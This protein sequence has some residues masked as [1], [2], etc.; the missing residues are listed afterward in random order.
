MLNHY[1]KQTSD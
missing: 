1:N